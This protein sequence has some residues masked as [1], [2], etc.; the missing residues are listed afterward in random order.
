MDVLPDGADYSPI[1][2]ALKNGNYFVTSGEVLIP[3]H[4]FSFSG[5]DSTLRANLQWTFPLEFVEIVTGDGETTQT[6][7][8]NAAEL[9]AFGDQ[10]FSIPFDASGQRWERFAAWDTAGNGAMTMPIR[11]PAP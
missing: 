5:A 9:Q 1:I 8:V 4:T 10:S 2:A 3:E 6:T 11:I 7:I